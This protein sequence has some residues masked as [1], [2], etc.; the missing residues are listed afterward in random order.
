MVGKSYY[1]GL[2]LEDNL[3][4][5]LG[6]GKQEVTRTQKAASGKGMSHNKNDR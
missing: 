1:G 4:S 3:T 2:L 6:G 5:I